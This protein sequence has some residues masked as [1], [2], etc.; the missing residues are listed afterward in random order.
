MLKGVAAA[1][2]L[3]LLGAAEPWDWGTD[4]AEWYDASDYA[5]SKAICRAVA[6]REPPA[7]DRPD[8]AAVAALKDCDSEAFLYGIGMPPDPVKARHCAFIEAE[9][10]QQG[11]G[12]FG[13]AA[14]MTI[15]ANGS[16]VERNLDVAIHL[17]CGVEGAPAES[18]GR[19]LHLAALKRDGPGE[20]PF[21]FCDNITSGYAGGICAA[22]GARIQDAE[23]ETAIAA[24]TAT[25]TAAE[26]EALAKLRAAHDAYAEAHAGGEI[27]MSGTL[28]WAFFVSAQ[29]RLRGELLAMLQ[30]LEGGRA[31]K[32]GAADY[33]AADT[34]LNAEY[35]K[36]L[37]ERDGEQEFPGK[38]TRASV[39][40]A[41][42][43]WL[44]YRDA[45]LALA[46]IRYSH[47]SRDGLGAWLTRQRTELLLN[48]PES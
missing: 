2:M 42:R 22:H 19:V 11:A 8:P 45:F 36:S 33:R 4:S 38:V 37:R 5:E 10:E 17:A 26:K 18:H 27:D 34:R 25:W 23:R 1:A 41:Q 29:Q 9:A 30:D 15:Y 13:R 43:A 39:R 47:A 48:P 28:R 44:R 16:G 14:L 24:L 3:L 12:V 7:A 31:P 6:N 32:L 40:E 35:R 46:A 20:E 21:H